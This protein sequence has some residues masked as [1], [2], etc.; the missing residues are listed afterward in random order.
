MIQQLGGMGNLMEMIKDLEGMEKNGQL[1][2]LGK[3]IGGIN[4]G[5]GKRQ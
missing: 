5:K 1:G 3:M 2:D 4:K